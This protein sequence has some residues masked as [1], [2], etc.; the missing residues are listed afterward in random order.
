MLLMDLD[1][2][3]SRFADDWNTFILF[4]KTD[5]TCME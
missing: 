1:L 3:M 4:D 2:M 5:E